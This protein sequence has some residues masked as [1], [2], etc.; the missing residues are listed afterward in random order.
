MLEEVQRRLPEGQKIKYPYLSYKYSQIVK[1]HE[2]FYPESRIRAVSRFLLGMALV[3]MGSLM[4][5]SFGLVM[6]RQ[7]TQIK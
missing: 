4:I 7:L 2:L 3:T 1:A 5:I 6:F